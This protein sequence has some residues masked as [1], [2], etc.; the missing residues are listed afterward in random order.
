MWFQFG[1]HGIWKYRNSVALC[2][3]CVNVRISPELQ[4][5]VRGVSE[6]CRRCSAEADSDTAVQAAWPLPSCSASN[7][8]AP[9][10]LSPCSPHRLETIMKTSHHSSIPKLTHV[11]T[12]V[13]ACN[14]SMYLF[15]L[16]LCLVRTPGVL[17]YLLIKYVKLCTHTN[18]KQDCTKSSQK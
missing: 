9:S 2:Q 16:Y 4:W 8:P 15:I 11:M 12:H 7:I 13:T 5:W 18:S 14:S 3:S 1:P 10:G 6:T 17:M